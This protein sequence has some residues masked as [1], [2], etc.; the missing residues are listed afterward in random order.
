MLPHRQTR[1]GVRDGLEKYWTPAQRACAAP[2]PV[3][4]AFVLADRVEAHLH[5]AEAGLAGTTITGSGESP[6]PRIV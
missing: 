1:P 3:R 5:D 2:L 4:A 6:F